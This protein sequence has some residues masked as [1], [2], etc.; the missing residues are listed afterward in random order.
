VKN[1]FIVVAV[2]LLAIAVIFAGC[3][4]SETSKNKSNKIP[5]EMIGQKAVVISVHKSFI[6]P[7]DAETMRNMVFVNQNEQEFLHSMNVYLSAYRLT[8]KNVE[9]PPVMI[10]SII[11]SK[12]NNV[13]TLSMYRTY[14]SVKS[15][16]RGD[17]IEVRS[18]D[19]LEKA[20]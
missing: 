19:M 17:M 12:D 7:R 11:V 3:T 16:I 18:E 8:I 14:N 6:V 13:D 15:V 1:L 10:S 5:R 20:R 9:L 2:A 4:S